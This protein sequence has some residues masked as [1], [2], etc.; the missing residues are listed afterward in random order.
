MFMG[1]G[2]HSKLLNNQTVI[3]IFNGTW[4]GIQCGLYKT[5]YIYIYTLYIFIYIYIY[6]VRK[7]NSEF[8]FFIELSRLPSPFCPQNPL[9]WVSVVSNCFM[10]LEVWWI[11]GGSGAESICFMSPLSPPSP[12]TPSVPIK[13]RPQRRCV[14]NEFMNLCPRWSCFMPNVTPMCAG[15]I[16]TQSVSK[17]VP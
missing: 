1:H 13:T 5:N 10:S 14:W 11:S 17:I 16:Y 9:L 2:F 4:M 12:P 7:L 6:I 15:I 8:F 3:V